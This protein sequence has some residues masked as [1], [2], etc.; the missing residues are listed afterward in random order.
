[1]TIFQSIKNKLKKREVEIKILTPPF[2]HKYL[3]SDSFM[4][5]SRWNYMT[6]FSGLDR[7]AFSLKEQEIIA[8]LIKEDLW[9]E[10]ETNVLKDMYY[11][12]II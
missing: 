10:E 2:P 4:H 5:K 3:P 11:Y 1:L 9:I 6:D 7:K 8:K 12:S